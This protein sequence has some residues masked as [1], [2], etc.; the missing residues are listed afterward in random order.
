MFASITQLSARL[1]NGSNAEQQSRHMVSIAI[2]TTNPKPNLQVLDIT[3]IIIMK[4][5]KK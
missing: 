4:K 2:F 5:V 3:V 1:I